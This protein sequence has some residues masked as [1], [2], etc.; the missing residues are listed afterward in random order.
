MSFTY[1]LDTNI[2]K[3]RL[4]IPDTDAS[5]YVFE[6]DELEYFL[7]KASSD[8]QWAKVYVYENLY[9]MHQ[10]SSG[11]ETE[12]GDIR[13]KFA[14]TLGEGWKKMADALR[15]LLLSGSTPESSYNPFFYTGGIYQQ[16]REDW[17]ESIRDGTL[18]E[19]DFYDNYNESGDKGGL[20]S[21]S[22]ED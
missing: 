7:N 8:I 12:V 5:N 9:A 2:G 11:K 6:D 21:D 1:D 10:T 18:I 19:R 16:D 17:E 14:A 15:A 20:L 22:D 3:L 13:I 4:E